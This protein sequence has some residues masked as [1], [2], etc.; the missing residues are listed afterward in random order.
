MIS[1]LLTQL[2]TVAPTFHG[3]K[4]LAEINDFPYITFHVDS[5]QRIHYGGNTQRENYHSGSIFGLA[6]IYIRGYVYAEDSISAAEDL[7]R[8]IEIAL[9]MR[10]S[11]NTAN[12]HD[13]QIT[14]VST[15]EGL[16]APYGIADIS[17]TVLVQK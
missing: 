7:A 11:F 16:L 9:D 3:L 1:T 8:E 4:Y 15:D 12:I 6:S 14:T 17:A 10:S 13:I 2:N 5:E